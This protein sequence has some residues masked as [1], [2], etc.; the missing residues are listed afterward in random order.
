M[1]VLLTFAHRFKERVKL[2]DPD[3]LDIWKD[4]F[5]AFMDGILQGR[6]ETWR[7]SDTERGLMYQAGNLSDGE[8]YHGSIP[9]INSL[10]SV[11]AE[12]RGFYCY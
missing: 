5:K 3:Q 4:I 6:Y 2:I 1:S 12:S 9:V 11:D 7:V 10:R 8:K